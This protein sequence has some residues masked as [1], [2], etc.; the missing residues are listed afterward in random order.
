MAT[1]RPTARASV[2]VLDRAT[3]AGSS[4]SRKRGTGWE[5]MTLSTAIFSGS[6]ARRRCQRSERHR[7]GKPGGWAPRPQAK[8]EELF[9]SSMFLDA[10]EK[11]T[12]SEK[13]L[14]DLEIPQIRIPAPADDHTVGS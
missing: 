2:A 9:S 10:H 3:A 14:S 12:P 1:R 8:S 6:G 7:D 4:K 5:P 11:A 13:P